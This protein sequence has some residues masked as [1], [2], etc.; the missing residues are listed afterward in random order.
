MLKK[1]LYITA[2]LL[3]FVTLGYF[4][5]NRYYSASEKQVFKTNKAEL[6]KSITSDKKF[7]KKQISLTNNYSIR[8]FELENNMFEVE[9]YYKDSKIH[10]NEFF[11][12]LTNDTLIKKV[13]LDSD[14]GLE[15]C[16][17]LYNIGSTYGSQTNIIVWDN[18]DTWDYC[19][20]P[21]EKGEVEDRNND[22]IY[23]I[24]EYYSKYGKEGVYSF[25]KGYF[26]LTK[27]PI[28]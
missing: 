4:L 10:S 6:R 17:T 18:D 12:Y 8:L 3:V 26:S 16:I 5:Y 28:N 2:I 1:Q 21:F 7:Y 20:A 14:S 19:V 15:Y 9:L 27:L 22:G 25:D 13:N 11:G 23:E 24:V